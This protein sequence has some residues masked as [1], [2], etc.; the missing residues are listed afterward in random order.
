MFPKSSAP[1]LRVFSDS[2]SYAAEWEEPVATEQQL[3]EAPIARSSGI[4]GAQ[5]R[6]CGLSAACPSAVGNTMYTKPAAAPRLSPAVFL[7][8]LPAAAHVA[9]QASGTAGYGSRKMHAAGGPPE[10]VHTTSPAVRVLLEAPSEGHRAFPLLSSLCVCA[11]VC[12]GHFLCPE[13]AM[14]HASSG[15]ALVGLACASVCLHFALCNT[16]TRQR[17]GLTDTN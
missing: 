9:W 4:A 12:I 5:M 1:S 6:I 7:G 14:P 2:A 15:T 11:C 17:G 3:R 13:A 10:A 8:V 16:T